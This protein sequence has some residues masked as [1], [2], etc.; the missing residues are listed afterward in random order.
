M[1]NLFLFLWKYNFFIFFLLLETLCGYLI[2]RNSNFQRTSIVNS[3]NK[4]AAKVSSVVSSVTDY[5]QLGATNEALSRENASLKSLLPGMFYIDSALTHIN[6]DTILKRQYSYMTAKVIDN[7]VNRRNNY[8]TLNKGSLQ[9]VTP[10]MGVICSDG[11]VGT[12]KDVSPHF[13]SVMSFLHKDAKVSSKFLHSDYFGEMTWNGYDQT[14]GN[15]NFIA[16]HVKVQKGDT[17]ITTSFDDNIPEG[18]MV[19][20]VTSVG[21]NSGDNFQNIDVKLTTPFGKL[22]YVYI[23]ENVLKEEQKKLEEGN[24]E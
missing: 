11:I 7:S 15:M 13:C 8:L 1:R 23:V 22:T 3:T 9:G 24:Q 6:N 5:I 18:I 17:I 10:G 2:F 21:L 4:V 14:K 20:V 12:V 16:M 19:G